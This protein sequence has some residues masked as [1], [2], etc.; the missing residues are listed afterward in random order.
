MDGYGRG[1]LSLSLSFFKPQ[2]LYFCF[3]KNCARH[4][5]SICLSLLKEDILFLGSYLCKSRSM[6]Y[7]NGE[8]VKEEMMKANPCLYLAIFSVLG[9]K[10]LCFLAW[11]KI[12]Y[13]VVDSI[14]ID[15]ILFHPSFYFNNNPTC[16][17][18]YYYVILI[19]K[20]IIY[21]LRKRNG[22]RIKSD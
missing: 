13:S 21:I 22:L 11:I 14:S 7:F 4:P 3:S 2:N 18:V 20:Y 6:V 15:F 5:L 16:W 1:T 17:I 10:Y 8:N 19:L 9:L 12:P